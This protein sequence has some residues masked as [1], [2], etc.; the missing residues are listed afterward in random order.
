MS[1]VPCLSST[2]ST[3]ITQL[4]EGEQEKLR[5]MAGVNV[6]NLERSFALDKKNETFRAGDSYS[7]C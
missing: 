7:N 1:V 2:A 6:E 5:I 4:E 3:G